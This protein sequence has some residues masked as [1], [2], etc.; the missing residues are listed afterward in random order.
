MHRE[1]TYSLSVA[2]GLIALLG[3]IGLAFPFFYLVGFPINIPLALGAAI[4]LVEVLEAVTR[5][6][7]RVSDVAGTAALHA[8]LAAGAAWLGAVVVV[9]LG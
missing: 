9:L 1:S 2:A 7:F 5:Y 8:A 6:R 3:A 4:F